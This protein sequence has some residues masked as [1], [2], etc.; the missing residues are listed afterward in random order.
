MGLVTQTS[1]RPAEAG[2]TNLPARGTWIA[3]PA[4]AFS[5]A[6]L[7]ERL[8]GLTRSWRDYPPS[9]R[10]WFWLVPVLTSVIGGL[11]RFVRLDT[12]HSLFFDETYYVKD[13]YSYLV[14]GY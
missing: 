8:I 3:R 14:S 5:A 9:L 2:Q 13:A 10:F 7:R 11:L 12:P 1:M 4:E 6:A